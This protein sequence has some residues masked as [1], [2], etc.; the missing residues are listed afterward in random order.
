MSDLELMAWQEEERRFGKDENELLV[1]DC[2][3]EFIKYNPHLHHLD[4]Q[5]CGL[6]THILED[7]GR[8]LR[9]SRSLVGIHLSENPGLTPEIK[10]HLFDRVHCKESDQHKL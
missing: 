10:Q 1:A 4:L 2:L 5:G 6:T 9:K 8:A 7:I 3:S